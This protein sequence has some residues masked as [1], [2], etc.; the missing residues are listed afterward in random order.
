[1]KCVYREDMGWLNP[2]CENV[3]EIRRI[4]PNY[5]VMRDTYS[6]ILEIE[7][8]EFPFW[9]DTKYL[10]IKYGGYCKFHPHGDLNKE[11]KFNHLYSLKDGDTIEVKPRHVYFNRQEHLNPITT[12]PRVL[13]I[14]HRAHLELPYDPTEAQIKAFCAHIPTWDEATEYLKRIGA[15]MTCVPEEEMYQNMKKE[16]H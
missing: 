5:P 9:C 13:C 7:T 14:M 3:G 16:E 4:I 1:M 2:I 12:D 11:P 6:H 15:L 10:F 8:D